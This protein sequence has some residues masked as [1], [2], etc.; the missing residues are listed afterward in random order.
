MSKSL[1]Q[2]KVNFTHSLVAG[3]LLS[4]LSL[5]LLPGSVAQADELAPV[6]I[7]KPARIEVYPTSVQL[8]SPRQFRYLVVTA[9]YADGQ[10][11]DITRAAEFSSTN[12][13]VAEIQEAV[14]RPQ[15]DGKSE[16]V[17]RAGGQEAKITVEV[18]GQKATESISFGTE[19]TRHPLSS[20]SCF[21]P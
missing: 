15:G 12:P 19:I 16:V 14:V 11:Q 3:M 7:G 17:V 9:H 8:T 18:S 20:S 6:E 1:S 4:G 13:Q 5:L 10:V 2:M 21:T